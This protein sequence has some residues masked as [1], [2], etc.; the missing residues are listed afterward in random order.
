[1]T[2]LV[3]HARSLLAY[4]IW[5]DQR[6][7][8]AA[9][10]IAA[11]E[12]QQVQN[13]VEHMLGTQRFWQAAWSHGAFLVNPK[14]PSLAIAREAYAASH[15]ALRSFADALTQEEWDRAEPWWK[16]WGYD[17]VMPLG[18]SIAQLFY[19]G[20]QHRSEVAILLSMWGHSPGDMD[21]LTYLAELRG[22]PAD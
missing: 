18:E 8:A 9:D 2:T 1:M 13:Q 4:T 20:A 19:H 7:L 16:Q 21:Y 15:D 6:I 12:W 5:G 17:A 10:G 3:D 22:L 11:D 14:L